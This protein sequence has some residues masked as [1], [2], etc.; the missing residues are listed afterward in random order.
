[1]PKLDRENTLIYPHIHVYNTHILQM[2]LTDNTNPKYQI[3]YQHKSK[4]K[5]TE[6]Y[7]WSGKCDFWNLRIALSFLKSADI[8]IFKEKIILL[9]YI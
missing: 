1:M 2:L 9:I 4:C 5:Y 3:E 6:K 7:T 8:S